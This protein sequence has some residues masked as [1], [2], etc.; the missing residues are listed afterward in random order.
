ML[1]AAEAAIDSGSSTGSDAEHEQLEAYRTTHDL[2]E[3]VQGAVMPPLWIVKA[4]NSGWVASTAATARA[5][6]DAL[7]GVLSEVGN[8]IASRLDGLADERSR[9]AAESWRTREEHDRPKAGDA[10]T[11][12]LSPA[13][14]SRERSAAR[15]SSRRQDSPA[16]RATGP[17]LC[18]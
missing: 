15:R 11:R 4:G 9:A 7:L 13:G 10:G 3:A 14:R 1:A 12:D 8:A 17:R 16:H 2:A 6:F 18:G 5:P